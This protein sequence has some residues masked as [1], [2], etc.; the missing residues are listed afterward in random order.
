MQRLQ[1][2]SPTS[3]LLFIFSHLSSPY[4]LISTKKKPKQEKFRNKIIKKTSLTFLHVWNTTFY[5][6]RIYSKAYNE[7]L[8]TNLRKKSKIMKQFRPNFFS[9]TSLA[10]KWWVPWIEGRKIG[11]KSNPN[12]I[13]SSETKCWYTVIDFMSTASSSFL[14]VKRLQC[15]CKYKSN[16]ESEWASFFLKMVISGTGFFFLFCATGAVP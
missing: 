1:K 9:L 4:K 11:K 2:R 5:H 10:A 6:H 13:K 15:E 16:C 12:Q 8:E 7:N 3:C 14:I